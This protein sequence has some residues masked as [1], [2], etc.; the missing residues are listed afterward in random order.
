MTRVGRSPCAAVLH[1]HA[2]ALLLFDLLTSLSTCPFTN[3]FFTDLYA[4]YPQACIYLSSCFLPGTKLLSQVNSETQWLEAL[5]P[6]SPEVRC[7]LSHYSCLHIPSFLSLQARGRVGCSIALNPSS[8]PL[9]VLVERTLQPGIPAIV[10]WP[11]SIV[12][13]GICLAGRTEPRAE[14]FYQG[15]AWE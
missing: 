14:E 10:A 15:V 11:G 12:A 7:Q 13:G 3:F 2:W 9:S 8:N 4:L 5:R 1:S 6:D